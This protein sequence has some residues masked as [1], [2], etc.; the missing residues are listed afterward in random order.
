MIYQSLLGVHPDTWN[1]CNFQSTTGWLYTGRSL[2]WL[3]ISN[4]VCLQ[5][6]S[7]FR[8]GSEI[9]NPVCLQSWPQFRDLQRFLIPCMVWIERSVGISI[10]LCLSI[11]TQDCCR[12]SLTQG[13]QMCMRIDSSV[14]CIGHCPGLTTGIVMPQLHASAALLSRCEDRSQ[15]STIANPNSHKRNIASSSP[16]SYKSKPPTAHKESQRFR[17]TPQ[18]LPY[19]PG[20]G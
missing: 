15:L 20:E 17:S 9:F 7:Q 19:P 6:W 13:L 3:E 16:P 4:P 12:W 8:D 2:L 14:F 11:G 1:C 18:N 5:S 10:P